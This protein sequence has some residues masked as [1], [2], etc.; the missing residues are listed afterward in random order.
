M[1][2]ISFDA[3]IDQGAGAPK[4]L[5]NYCKSSTCIMKLLLTYMYMYCRVRFIFNSNIHV[6]QSFPERTTFDFLKER[7]ALFSG[8]PVTRNTCKGRH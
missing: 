8:E 7:K 1:G 2:D 4:F 6:L 3:S 5:P